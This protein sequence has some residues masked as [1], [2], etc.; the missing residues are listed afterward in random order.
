[1]KNAEALPKN[2]G[3]CRLVTKYVLKLKG[4]RLRYTVKV[5]IIFYRN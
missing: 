4:L 5:Y 2:H 1:M 3:H